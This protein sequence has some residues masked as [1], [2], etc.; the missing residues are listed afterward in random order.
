M[1]HCVC[2]LHTIHVCV[3]IY[4]YISLSLYIYICVCVCVCVCVYPRTRVLSVYTK[5]DR[6]GAVGQVRFHNHVALLTRATLKQ[7]LPFP[8][9]SLVNVVRPRAFSY[10]T[11]IK[12]LS[13]WT[14]IKALSYWTIIKA[15][16]YWTIIKASCRSFPVSFF[17]LHTIQSFPVKRYIGRP[18]IF[19]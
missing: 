10:W 6:Y 9:P 18:F 3:R 16:S 5:I 1:C 7:L 2:V 15:L 4:I 13:Y 19:C 11:I 17:L 12:A 8:L 14:I